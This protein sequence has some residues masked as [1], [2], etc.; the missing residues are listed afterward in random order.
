MQQLARF[1]DEDELWLKLYEWAKVNDTKTKVRLVCSW[2]T[3]S[4]AVNEFLERDYLEIQKS[5]ISSS[6]VWS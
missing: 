5:M 4:D 2:T 3:D 1:F 6:M